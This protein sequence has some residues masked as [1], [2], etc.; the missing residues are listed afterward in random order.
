[1][2]IENKKRII[3]IQL[4][5]LGVLVVFTVVS[6]LISYNVFF[7]SE[8]LPF[9]KA[10]IITALA[11]LYVIHIVLGILRR[12]GYFYFSD[13]GSKLIVRYY[14]LRP[15]SKQKSIE[16]KKVDFLGYKISKS[17]FGFRRSLIMY[18]KISQRK[19]GYPPVSLTKL[20]KS[21]VGD[22]KLILNNYFKSA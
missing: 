8:A 11:A 9:H 10:W 3:T 4:T 18:Q 15:F 22:L 21:Q 1:M 13:M 14:V 12:D 6:V 17:I 2:I 16:I 20:S 7:E 5:R 19:A